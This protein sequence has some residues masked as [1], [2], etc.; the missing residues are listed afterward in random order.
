VPQSRAD[1][2]CRSHPF[3]IAL[4]AVPILIFGC[5]NSSGGTAGPN[6]NPTPT[7]AVSG[8]YTGSLTGTNGNTVLSGSITANLA[9]GG[10]GIT[11]TFSITSSCF[12]GSLN[13]TA[14]QTSNTQFGGTGA[15]NS[16]DRITFA[17]AATST[18]FQSMSGTIQVNSG[19]CA[20]DVADVT[21]ARSS[22][23]TQLPPSAL[24]FVSSPPAQ[25]NEGSFYTYTMQANV[26]GAAFGLTSSPAGAALS[27][28]TITWT[29]TPQQ[30]RA[31]NQFAV[32]ASYAGSTATQNWTVTPTG[33]IRGTTAETCLSDSGQTII[34]SPEMGNAV[35]VLV[36]NAVGGF[37]TYNSTVAQDGTFSIPNIPAGSFWLMTV[38]TKVWTSNST[39]NVG[40]RFWGDCHQEPVSS[41]GTSLQIPITGL[42][43]WQSQ[44]YLYFAVPNQR[45]TAPPTLPATGA[46]STSETIPYNNLLLFSS[47]NGDNAYAAQLV[48]ASYAGISFQ[49]LECFSG[50]L[51]ITVQN[52]MVNSFPVSLQSETQSSSVRAN[53]RGSAFAALYPNMSRSAMTVNP[54]DNFRVDITPDN[55]GPSSNGLFL[56]LASHA[57]SS[58]TDAG[59]IPFANPFPVSWTPYLDYTDSAVQ[60][61]TPPGA[62]S[63]FPMAV[64]N[65]VVT[66]QF[67]TASNPIAP[68]IGPA[69]NP[70]INGVSLFQDQ[71]ISSSTPVLS[72]QA[73]ALGTAYIYDIEVIGFSVANGSPSVHRV[74]ELYTT[75][76]SIVLPQGL[77]SSGNSYCFVIQ[78]I[79]RKSL[80][81]SVAP[82]VETFPEGSAD[83]ISGVISVQ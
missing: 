27:G 18:S 66:A 1:F 2:V 34:I 36:P 21:L 63:P 56:V 55:I 14:G 51:P 59:D 6:P 48:N 8:T 31:A 43:P 44:D 53:V 71:T 4:V 69:L 74:D 3:L 76:T 42:N 10:A 81:S 39:I 12:Q 73:P 5:N 29:P 82:Y 22:G 16:G 61:L 17:F 19:P 47:A 78:S 68:V 70:Q 52:G 25:A 7:G 45:S 11:G 15:D 32:T 26:Q 75:S 20:G 37:D 79:S 67:P 50:P 80:D 54:G 40:Y 83:V 57:F 23:S 41:A 38:G 46:S 72:W 33:T 58:D 28:N 77:L 35:Q 13:V 30:S 60:N 65:R 62:S 64:A 49:S 24:K 9:G